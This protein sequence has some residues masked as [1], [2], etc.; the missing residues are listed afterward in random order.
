MVRKIFIALKPRW[1]KEGTAQNAVQTLITFWIACSSTF[2]THLPDTFPAALG[3]RIE[4][5]E[6]VAER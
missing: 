2:L 6:D 1:P 3:I 4:G 5:W